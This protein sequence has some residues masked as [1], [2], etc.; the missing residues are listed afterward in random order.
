MFKKTTKTIVIIN[1]T[2]FAIIFVLRTGTVILDFQ[3]P[4]SRV[5]HAPHAN[6]SLLLV[7]L[8]GEGVWGTEMGRVGVGST[9]FSS[10]Q[11]SS[12]QSCL[13]LCDPMDCSTPGL[14]VYDQ[15]LELT[16]T[17]VC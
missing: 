3:P 1:F 17:H 4:S 9:V 11:F 14:P 13:T 7:R 16:Q 6:W 2:M 8:R 15:L 5:Q 12:V 10:L